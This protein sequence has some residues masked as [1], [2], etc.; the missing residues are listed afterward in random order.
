VS[1]VANPTVRR[2]WTT[3]PNSDGTVS[4]IK[5]SYRADGHVSIIHRIVDQHGHTVVVWH[6]V[7]S[8]DGQIVHGPEEK[9]RRYG[10]RGDPDK[11]A[12]KGTMMAQLTLWKETTEMILTYLDGKVSAQQ[13]TA[14]A[15]QVVAAET[16]RS[17]EVLLEY[18]ILSLLEL[19]DRDLP[20]ILPKE[21]L[22]HLLDCLLGK[23][24]LQLEISYSPKP[25]QVKQREVR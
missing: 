1:E 8:L 25:L 2:I 3:V 22:E 16:F 18:A 20:F 21:E 11:S 19:S 12:L 4:L 9:F 5:E 6:Y 13:V 7:Y 10:Y 24:T 17:D 23:Q 15:T 14:W